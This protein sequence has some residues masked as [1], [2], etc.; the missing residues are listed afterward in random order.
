MNLIQE[1]A[2]AAELC[3]R[4]R[5]H[6]AITIDTE[7][8]RENTYWPKLCLIQLGGPGEAAAIDPLAGGMDLGPVFDLLDDRSVVK[9]FHSGR[10]DIEIFHH[11]SG[12]IPAPIFDTQIAAMVCGFGDAVSYE[13]LIARLTGASIDKTSR[14]T[15]WSHRPLT[16]RQLAYALDDVIHLRDAYAALV[17]HLE[18]SGRTSW[19]DDEMAVLTDPATYHTE[20]REAWRRLK[21]RSASPKFLAVLREVAAWR[22]QEAQNRDIPR[23]RILRDEALQ[24][25][26]AHTPKT[27]DELTRTRGLTRNMAEGWQGEALL[28]AVKRGLN[29]ANDQRPRVAKSRPLPDGIG[30]T[31]ELLKVLLKLKCEQHGVAQKLLG[32][33]ADLERI[34]AD[35]DA[36]VPALKGWRRELFGNDALALKHGE[37]ALRIDRGAVQL[38]DLK[39]SVA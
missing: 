1:S 5:Q 23:N 34:A 37:I 38:V 31:V 26:A 6:D 20:P 16:N 24:E 12:R 2:E 17:K 21:T 7:F 30:P 13:K 15:D 9:I 29:V 32:S 28:A 27:V 19:L 3:G 25:I 8:L 36:E 18:E 11:L 14:F 4:L 33:T 35:D 10:Q 39:Q 22:E